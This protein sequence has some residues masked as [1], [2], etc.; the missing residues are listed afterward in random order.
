MKIRNTFILFLLSAFSCF[1]GTNIVTP[2]L[3][4]QLQTP[5]DGNAQAL[6]NVVYVKFND[7]TVQTTASSG[8]GGVS[9]NLA[10][11]K[12]Y[13]GNALSNA[14]A[15]PVSGA[16]SLASN[17]ATAYVGVQPITTGGTGQ[18][19][20]SAAWYALSTNNVGLV[21]IKSFGA[22][23]G[24]NDD[25]VPF[26]NALNSG[27]AVF[28][29]PSLTYTVGALTLTNNSCLI[30]ANSHIIFKNGVLGYMFTEVS[31]VNSVHLENLVLDGNQYGFNAF[32]GISGSEPAN[33]AYTAGFLGISQISSSSNRSGLLLNGDSTNTYVLACTF[34]G[35]TDSGARFYGSTAFPQPQVSYAT[36][37]NCASDNNWIG[38]DFTTNAEYM[39]LANLQTAECG[40]GLAIQA[41]NVNILGGKDTH[42][43]LA[44]YVNGLANNPA[45]GIIA[46]RTM[47]HCYM[48]IDCENV[49]NDELFSDDEMFA[50]GSITLTNSSGIT[51]I[52]GVYYFGGS[53]FQQINTND[54]RVDGG[55]GTHSGMNYFQPGYVPPA[56][57]QTP[58]NITNFNGG[59]LLV[60]YSSSIPITKTTNYALSNFDA[61]VYVNG[62][63]NITLPTALGTSNKVVT[64]KNLAGSGTVNIL[65]TGAQTIDGLSF[66]SLSSKSTITVQADGTNWEI[67]N[68]LN[69]ASQN[70]GTNS[71]IQQNSGNETVTNTLSTSIAKVTN[72][73]TL[74]ALAFANV[75][76]TTAVVT[77]GTGNSSAIG[78]AGTAT[79]DANSDDNIQII[80][81]TTAGTPAANAF[82]CQI[83]FANAKTTTNRI[84]IIAPY[85]SLGTL[86]LHGFVDLF[87]TNFTT[88]SYQIWSGGTALTTGDAYKLGVMLAQ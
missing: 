49:P 53:A 25:T 55:T 6:S 78:L 38:F 65:T 34:T 24:G 11:A 51:I 64:I 86:S 84:G 40:R 14:T 74:G 10:P 50:S 7:G 47:N 48:G 36:V 83:N 72:T 87:A 20:A 85:N 19:T 15:Q 42:D 62:S 16:I 56:S 1:G 71:A 60:N 75:S 4:G 44:V 61:T 88:A 46:N 8:S 68:T 21:N 32:G 73:A 58:L 76:G 12:I 17:G 18:T 23:G 69:P 31:T 43:G 2:I 45:H 59:S 52:G 82:L 5:L 27:L 81:I 33:W 28:V 66:T 37:A 26:Q 63:T 57:L 22:L 13:I 80:N 70:V 30:G 41:G 29:D 39:S 35:F 54:I 77:N 79:L 9:T 3:N 67:L